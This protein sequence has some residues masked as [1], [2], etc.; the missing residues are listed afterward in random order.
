V[1]SR[2]YFVD[3]YSLEGV[4]IKSIDRGYF[5]SSSFG[6]VLGSRF[7]TKDASNNLIYIDLITELQHFVSSTKFSTSF[8]LHTEGK[9]A[10]L[11]N[12]DVA[13]VSITDDV[14]T[15][16]TAPLADT[17]ANSS[18]KSVA[19]SGNT[20]IVSRNG[21][22]IEKF[23]LSNGVFNAGEIIPVPS[24]GN[25][26]TA[27]SYT[28][29]LTADKYLMGNG[30]YFLVYDRSFNY[31]GTLKASS[32]PGRPSIERFGSTALVLG[33]KLLIGAYQSKGRAN[34]STNV[35][36]V[37]YA[38]AMFLFNTNLDFKQEVLPKFPPLQQ[39]VIGDAN[40][41]AVATGRV[42]LYDRKLNKINIY[43]S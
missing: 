4:F 26:N 19:I 9:I 14:H 11:N 13:I 43:S 27:P 17:G 32:V 2:A 10:F 37:A 41:C 40:Y 23:T 15:Y 28:T 24:F 29:L 6:E 22:S 16:V 20:V 1:C 25:S 42:Y 35:Y 34:Y 3:V 39:S 31:L 7:Y 5:A 12:T 38:G 30:Y 36:D 33:S 18:A 8:S 21:A